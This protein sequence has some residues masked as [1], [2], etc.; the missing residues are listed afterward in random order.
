MYSVRLTVGSGG[1]SSVDPAAPCPFC[2]TSMR[3]SCVH[4][5]VIS[6]NEMQHDSRSMN[7]T[8]FIAAS[9]GFLLLLPVG[10]GPAPPM[11][12]LQSKVESRRSK[13]LGFQTLE[14]STFDFRLFDSS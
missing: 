13:S 8:R 3:A 1:F 2:C 4:T 5:A 10:A 9:S 7:G 14:P 11:E 6:R 12:I